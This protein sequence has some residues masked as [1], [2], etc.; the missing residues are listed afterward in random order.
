MKKPIKLTTIF[1][2][3]K[4]R[5]VVRKN[6]INDVFTKKAVESFY[7][8]KEAEDYISKTQKYD[9]D[10]IYHISVKSSKDNGKKIASRIISYV[11]MFVS[12]NNDINKLDI[13]LDVNS[14][15]ELFASVDEAEDYK[16]HIAMKRKSEYI[17]PDYFHNASYPEYIN[18]S[19]NDYDDLMEYN[20]KLIDN[21]KILGM[22]VI[23]R[24]EN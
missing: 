22:K 15:D 24:K 18:I 11:E 8:M 9:A 16:K 3:E 12:K 19:K 10:Y 4:P 13:L 1:V 14:D 21:N 5:Y 7:T 17:E 20:P 2:N 6:R 23:I